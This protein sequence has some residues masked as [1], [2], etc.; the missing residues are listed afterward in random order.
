MKILVSATEF[1]LPRQVAQILSDL[2]FYNMLLRQNS[3]AETEIF[4]KFP[5]SHEAI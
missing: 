5:S 3:V 4:A 2:I 1:L